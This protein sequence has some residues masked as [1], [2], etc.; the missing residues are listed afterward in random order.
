MKKIST[1]LL[2]VV[3]LTLFNFNVE[4]AETKYDSYAE[5]LSLINVFVGTGNGFD[6]DRAPTRLEGM[7]MLIRLLG[8][9]DEAKQL[10][11]ETSPFNDVP[12]WGNGYVVYAYRN[13]LTKGISSTEFGSQN[14]LQAKSYITFLLRALGYDDA[15]GDFTWAEAVEYAKEIGLLS[16]NMYFE[17]SSKTFLRDHV[18]KTSYDALE[19]KMKSSEITLIEYLIDKGSIDGEVAEQ[20]FNDTPSVE[21]TQTVDVSI[22][23]KSCVYLEVTTPQGKGSGSGFYIDSTGTIVTNYHVIDGATDILVVDDDGTEHSEEVVVKGYDEAL[24]IAIIK[25]DFK[26]THYVKLG[27]SNNAKVGDDVYAIGSPLGLKNTISEG[28]IGAFRDNF[29][30]ISASISPGSSGGAL[31]NDA[32]E[33]IGITSAKVV[34]TEAEGLGFAIPI[35]ELNTVDAT[36]IYALSE[37]FSQD[38]STEDNSIEF[39]VNAWNAEPYTYIQWTDIGVNKY[40]VWYSENGS[41]W[42]QLMNTNG[43]DYFTYTSGYYSVYISN[44]TDDTYYEI[45]VTAVNNEELIESNVVGLIGPNPSKLTIDELE[46]YLSKNKS[47]MVV[48]GVRIDFLEFS[49]SNEYGF[50]YIAVSMNAANVSKLLNVLMDSSTALISPSGNYALEI[51]E[52]LGEPVVLD[53]IYSDFVSSYPAPYAYNAIFG[54]P[55]SWS[56]INNSWQIFYPYIEI[57]TTMYN[58][59]YYLM[60][61]GLTNRY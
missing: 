44:F 55:V 29:I 10:S 41:D 22:L 31:F 60:D 38:E 37:L 26:S 56:I 1:I 39:I 30:Q 27:D 8:V 47:Y 24:D 7:V 57:E 59:Y 40:F 48:G 16:E 42:I 28:I 43:T 32:G 35:N 21:D 15:Y 4:A 17:I 46:D 19:I 2:L 51:Q 18:A 12:A 20:I 5:K 50:N 23:A 61:N 11:G 34:L 25:I 49:A 53:I 13:G 58:T 9:E 33:V 45:A 36:K 52:I 54:N 3:V 14:L 6:L